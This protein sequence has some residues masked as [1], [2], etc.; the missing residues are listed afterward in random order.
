LATS[1]V[2]FDCPVVYDGSLFQLDEVAQTNKKELSSNWFG[3]PQTQVASYE[4]SIVS[5]KLVTPTMLEN[6]CRTVSGFN[7]LPDVMQWETTRMR[8]VVSKT[9]LKLQE[10]ETYYIVVRTTLND[11]TLLFSNSNGV[12]VEPIVEESTIVQVETIETIG[13]PEKIPKKVFNKIARSYVTDSCPIDEANR[14]G[15]ATRVNAVGEHLNDLYGPPNWFQTSQAGILYRIPTTAEIA[16]EIGIPNFVR[17]V[18]SAHGNPFIVT[19]GTSSDDDDDDGGLGAGGIVALAVA[20]PVGTGV[21]LLALL[22]LLLLLL[23]IILLIIIICVFLLAPKKF[24]E[25]FQVRTN[26]VVDSDIGSRTDVSMGDS[27][28]RVEF[29]DLDAPS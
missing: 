29:P 2:R 3:L 1:T 17:V 6:T 22:L 7:G 26:D 19:N 25:N 20:I 9:D 16:E 15:Q 10:G 18:P 12:K 24:D 4:W 21:I 28:T 14:C 11:G 5:S 27:S 13:V 23:I 8:T